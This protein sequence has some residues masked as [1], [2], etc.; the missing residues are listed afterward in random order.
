MSKNLKIKTFSLVWKETLLHI[1]GSVSIFTLTYLLVLVDSGRKL[2]YP[3]KTPNREAPDHDR[4]RT[5][6]LHGVRQ[7]GGW[8]IELF[9]P[10]HR[11]Y[12]L[13]L[14]RLWCLMSP[15]L[16][17]LNPSSQLSGD[18]FYLTSA[19]ALVRQ[20]SSS[21]DDMV[22]NFNRVLSENP[23]LKAKVVSAKSKAPLRN[24]VVDRNKG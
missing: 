6:D 13:I 21:C 18:I 19:A 2:L 5:Q 3:E 24:N 9:V 11:H 20:D 1:K 14:G 15:H 4:N 8:V 10:D 12:H 22:A 17:L 16:L 7:L 23:A